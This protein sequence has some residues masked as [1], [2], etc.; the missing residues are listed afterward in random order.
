MGLD[1]ID[2]I[3]VCVS[4]G[5]LMFLLPAERLS[6][7]ISGDEL[8]SAILKDDEEKGMASLDGENVLVLSLRVL[9]GIPEGEER[10]ALILNEDR[11]TVGLLVD[12]VLET[13]EFA[14]EIEIQ[15][16]DEVLWEENSFLKGAVYIEARQSMAYVLDLEQLLTVE[17]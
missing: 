16:P 4:S 5:S 14:S 6:R 13:G 1:Q 9:L 17:E 7:I 2:G 10:H 15:L 8:K 12:E 3:S 11:G